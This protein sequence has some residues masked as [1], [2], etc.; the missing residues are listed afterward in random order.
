MNGMSVSV[1][2][3]TGRSVVGGGSR[4][5]GGAGRRS[6]ELAADDFAPLQ[7]GSGMRSFDTPRRRDT[8]L[9]AACLRR[10]P[11]GI[12]R[13]S[14]LH[15]AA[16]ADSSGGGGAADRRE[17]RSAAVVEE[18]SRQVALAVS[19]LGWSGARRLLV[20]PWWRAR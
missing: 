2:L 10:Y 6:T 5:V 15:G 3:V 20:L 7:K 19:L 18:G 17:R 9:S 11:I 12:R 1:R 8:A 16:A 14:L 4:W 13:V